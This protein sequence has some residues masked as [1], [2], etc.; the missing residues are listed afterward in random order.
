MADDFIPA[1]SFAVQI[2]T[3]KGIRIQAKLRR[4]KEVHRAVL[5]Q[6]NCDTW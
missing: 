6:P 5:K 3:I 4:V 1:H 2:T